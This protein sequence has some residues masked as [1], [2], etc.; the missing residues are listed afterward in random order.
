MSFLHVFSK[1][2]LHNSVVI[3]G[4]LGV[5]E[6]AAPV[7]RNTGTPR[8]A[9]YRPTA[10]APSFRSQPWVWGFDGWRMLMVNLA[11]GAM[12]WRKYPPHLSFGKR[13]TRLSRS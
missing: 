7:A 12:M 13:F 2:D 10:V 1:E 11:E 6:P 5:G 4:R 9:V 3:R 8:G